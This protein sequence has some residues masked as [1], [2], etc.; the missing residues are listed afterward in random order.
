MC[1]VSVW[2]RIMNY[3]DE[4]KV[5]RVNIKSDKATGIASSAHGSRVDAVGFN[6][7]LILEKNPTLAVHILKLY[8]EASEISN[9]DPSHPDEDYDL[10]LEAMKDVF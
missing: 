1:T 3:M 10:A 4:D 5:T 6:I 8:K 2:W 9:D 7:T